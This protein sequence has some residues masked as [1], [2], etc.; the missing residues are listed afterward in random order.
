MTQL[1]SSG[2]QTSGPQE[3]LQVVLA[4]GS[5]HLGTIL[6]RHLAAQGHMVR[7]MSRQRL[8]QSSRA[9]WWDGRN[10]GDWVEQL[11][12]TDVLINLSGRSVDCRYTAVH[13][14]EI[15]ESRIR[16][17]QLLGEALQRLDAPPRVW[18]NASTAT[19]YRHAL[20]RDMDESSG[21]I[22]GIDPNA[23][24][25]WGFSVDVARRWEDAFWKCDVR[26]T[27]KIALRTAMVMSPD[28]G[29]AFAALLRLVRW[30]LGGTIGDG[31]QYVSWIH[32][33][34]FARVIDHLISR[35]HVTGAINIAS[36]GPISNSVFMRILRA[37]WGNRLSIP[38]PRPI[39]EVGTLLLRTESELV[40]KSR[41]VVPRRL[42][43]DGFA[44]RF[45]HWDDAARDLVIRWKNRRQGRGID[46]SQ[47]L[48]RNEAA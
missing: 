45:P 17:T 31:S 22:G 34:D 37:A 33:A 39:L 2:S 41:R 26:G 15:L 32:D 11:S 23:S 18:L 42:L 47:P 16:T 8:P 27:R 6:Q 20:D 30:G 12:G 35:D 48:T 5:G 14:Q 9:I 10:M 1:P 38:A 40:L 43:N 4:G 44:F 19:I 28:E 13:R 36:P 7:V 46:I 24:N 3:P 29:G 25:E 21:E